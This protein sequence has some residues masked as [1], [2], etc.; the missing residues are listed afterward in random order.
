MMS[1]DAFRRLIFLLILLVA[2]FLIPV[3]DA[4]SNDAA[5]SIKSMEIV[6][7]GE[8]TINANPLAIDDLV[9]MGLQQPY[10][11]ARPVLVEMSVQC[12]PDRKYHVLVA[13]SIQ[14]RNKWGEW[15]LI[16]GPL[17]HGAA[18]HC[19]KLHE[20]RQAVVKRKAAEHFEKGY[21]LMDA[22]KHKEAITE[23]SN[24]IKL[25]PNISNAYFNR[26]MC[27]SN[28]KNPEKAISDYSRAIELHQQDADYFAQR[29]A[30]YHDLHKFKEA[31][32]DYTRAIELSYENIVAVY[33]R[34]AGCYVA[35]RNYQ[36]AVSD[37][38]KAIEL[39]PDDAD[40][41]LSRA[42]A[43]AYLSLNK[44]AIADYQKAAEL[45]SKDAQARLAAMKK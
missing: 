20:K 16:S 41:Y 4:E 32:S 1:V 10:Y 43:Y 31:I 17:Q 45:G 39:T 24:Y 15:V 18:S 38:T 34:R 5:Y 33:F 7:I 8:P 30:S 26:G 27:Y 12:P 23:F 25:V 29:G 36:A 22:G 35:I 44:K 6:K 37:L 28:L 9:M 14:A 3:P 11:V 2:S 13:E 21:R 40:N 42:E 19:T